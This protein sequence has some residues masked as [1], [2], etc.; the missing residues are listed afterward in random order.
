MLFYTP[1]QPFSKGPYPPK[2]APSGITPLAPLIRR[3]GAEPLLEP[4]SA[5]NPP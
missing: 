2:W 5:F 4:V 1:Q 3:E